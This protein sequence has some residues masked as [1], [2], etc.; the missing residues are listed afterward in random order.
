MF[1][2]KD[3]KKTGVIN[4]P[5]GYKRAPQGFQV[6][7]SLYFS[8][9]TWTARPWVSFFPC[10]SEPGFF[11]LTFTPTLIHASAYD[12]QMRNTQQLFDLC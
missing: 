12:L 6:A 9:C 11:V 10:L 4:W 2:H 1:K 5:G 3:G 8:F 7:G